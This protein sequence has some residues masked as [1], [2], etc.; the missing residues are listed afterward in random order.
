MI[1]VPVSYKFYKYQT[2]YKKVEVHLDSTLSYK[3][4]LFSKISVSLVFSFS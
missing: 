1:V 4:R 3:L 2:L